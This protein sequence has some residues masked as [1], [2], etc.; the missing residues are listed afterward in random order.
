MQLG[1]AAM[2]NSPPQWG[3]S[4]DRTAR[5]RAMEESALQHALYRQ[6]KLAMASAAAAVPQQLEGWEEEE[7][8]A[9]PSWG[10]SGETTASE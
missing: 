8:E 10:D 4:Y 6:A 1:A 7:E 5:A 9:E 3:A 2:L